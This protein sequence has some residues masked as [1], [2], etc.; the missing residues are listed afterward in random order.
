MCLRNQLV[1]S[2]AEPISADIKKTSWIYVKDTVLIILLR[3][4]IHNVKGHKQLT[5]TFY[6]LIVAYAFR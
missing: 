4:S 1:A 2:I 6:D 3:L 5:L